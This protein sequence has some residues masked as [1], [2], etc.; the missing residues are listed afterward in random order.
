[1]LFREV[2]IV[3]A[4][5]SPTEL[6]KYDFKYLRVLRNLGDNKTPLEVVPNKRDKYGNAVTLTPRSVEFLNKFFDP[7]T[8]SPMSD[9]PP[10]SMEVYVTTADGKRETQIIQTSSLFKSG[11]FKG[12]ENQTEGGKDYNAG[13]LTELFMGLAVSAKFF[14][15]GAPITKQQI[16]DMFGHMDTHSHEKTVEFTTTRTVVY[17]ERNNKNDSLYFSAKIP[18]GS[19]ESFIRQY[20]SGQF[21]EDLTAL[22]A[23]AVLYCNESASVKNAVEKVYRDKNNNKI[24]IASDGTG[25]ATSTKADLTLK[26]DGAKVN[27][28]SLKT[29]STKTLGQMSGLKFDTLKAFFDTAFGFDLGPYAKN[30]NDALSKEQLAKNL[31]NLYDTVIFPNVEQVVE[32]Q[33]PGVEAAIVKKLGRAALLFAR[34][35]KMEDV[36]VVKLNDKLSTGDY[37]ILKFGDDLPEVMKH[38]D[39]VAKKVGQG[40]NGR[41]IQI[42]VKPAPGER[43]VRNSHMLCQFRSQLQGGYMRNNFETGAIL[44]ALTEV[45]K[46]DTNKPAN[47]QTSINTDADLRRLK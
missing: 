34:G 46:P 32:Q 20:N 24:D 45:E 11:V 8:D 4:G 41:T 26:V 23:S 14:A 37:K 25:D 28:L 30:F 22:L 1:M 18:T 27:L 10:S 21:G 16:L 12:T 3:E 9:I 33:K 36:E 39:L 17:P 35:E 19:A 5:L 40:D 15:A 42:W 47:R 31:I 44:E 7:K 6:K 29:Y 2:F 43:V 13:H 38:Y